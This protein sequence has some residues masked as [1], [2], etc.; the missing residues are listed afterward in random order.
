MVGEKT[1][2]VTWIENMDGWMD[3]KMDGWMVSEKYGSW[4]DIK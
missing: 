1:W 4:M 2:I 3:K